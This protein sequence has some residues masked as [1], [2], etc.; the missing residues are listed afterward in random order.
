MHESRQ[1]LLAGQRRNC[2]PDL[3]SGVHSLHVQGVRGCAGDADASA[4]EE[5][6]QVKGSYG[7]KVGACPCW[8]SAAFAAASAGV[9]WI[10]GGVCRGFTGYKQ[11][12]ESSQA[13]C[14]VMGA[15]AWGCQN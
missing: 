14:W 9:R 5:E 7:T 13:K 15:A 6:I 2:L 1:P 11:M 12:E 8:P 10:E 4:G 3:S